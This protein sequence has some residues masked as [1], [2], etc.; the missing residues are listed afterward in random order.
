MKKG[1]LITF[2]FA[3]I[4][5]ASIYAQNDS[6]RTGNL[7]FSGS[8]AKKFINNSLHIIPELQILDLNIAKV[9]AHYELPLGPGL[10]AFGLEAGY[11]SGSRFGGSGYVDFFPLNVTASYA[12][13][14]ADIFFVGPSLK[15]GGLYLVS[16][17]WSRMEFMA[18]ARLEAELRSA[19]FPFGLFVGGGVDVFPNAHA[20]GILPVFEVGTRFPR[21]RLGLSRQNEEEN[22]A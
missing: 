21:G 7:F 18:G 8:Y 16:P 14:L 20:N 2:V 17:D 4:F 11:S 10:F 3:A 12:F 9:G 6:E 19:N 5:S 15:F 13:P 1:L 22:A